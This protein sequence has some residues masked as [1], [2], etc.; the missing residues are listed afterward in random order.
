MSTYSEIKHARLSETTL[1]TCYNISE[2]S[3][4]EIALFVYTR[5][6]LMHYSG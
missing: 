5:N 6:N 1:H 2:Q 3:H 4:K